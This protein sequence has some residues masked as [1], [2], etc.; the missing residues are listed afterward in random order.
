MQRSNG[1]GFLH[2]QNLQ[3]QHAKPDIKLLFPEKEHGSGLLISNSWLQPDLSLA[4]SFRKCFFS[5][6]YWGKGGLTLSSSDCSLWLSMF[7]Q[8]QMILDFVSPKANIPVS[9]R[10]ASS[11][12]EPWAITIYI[13]TLIRIS[14]YWY[15]FL[16]TEII[17]HI[18][19]SKYSVVKDSVILLW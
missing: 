19:I 17:I 8:A 16:T 12:A 2:E 7:D 9:S 10:A 15:F 5:V 3:K 6:L 18:F 11:H 4:R 14:F 13:S 1:Q